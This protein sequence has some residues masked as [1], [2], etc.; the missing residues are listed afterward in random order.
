MS[1][2]RAPTLAKI[3]FPLGKQWLDWLERLYLWTTGT[4]TV[5]TTQTTDIATNTAS[6][7]ALDYRLGPVT[8]IFVGTATIDFGVTA[9]GA[10]STSTITVTGASV[11]PSKPQG[12]LISN[13]VVTGGLV[14]GYVSSADTVTV[15]VVNLTAVDINPAS[16]VYTATVFEYG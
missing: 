13:V 14:D 11:V 16:K 9:P 4:D 8:A 12:V 3:A 2:F 6:I 10:T 1:I 5:Q 7:A 15:R